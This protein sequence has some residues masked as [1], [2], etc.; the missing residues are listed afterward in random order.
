MNKMNKVLFIICI[1]LMS[2]LYGNRCIVDPTNRE[3]VRNQYTFP[4]TIESEHFVIHFTTSDVD[5]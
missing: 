5:S 3:I 2:Q 4:E 1:M